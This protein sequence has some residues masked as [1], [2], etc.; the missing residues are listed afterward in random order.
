MVARLW[1]AISTASTVEERLFET[2][3]M[4]LRQAPVVFR[5]I[6]KIQTQYRFIKQIHEIESLDSMA[7][8]S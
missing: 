4:K 7:V 5:G 2:S 3:K 1:R 8:P 6:V